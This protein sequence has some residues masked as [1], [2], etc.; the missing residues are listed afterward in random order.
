[1]GRGTVPERVLILV[2]GTLATLSVVLVIYLMLVPEWD[3]AK[4][5]AMGTILGT[6]LSLATAILGVIGASHLS[7]RNEGGNGD[8]DTK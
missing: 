4:T 8:S 5:I 1:M 7:K 3:Q 2:S 6:L